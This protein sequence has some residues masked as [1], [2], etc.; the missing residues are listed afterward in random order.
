MNS[1][2]QVG[3]LVVNRTQPAW[4][5]GKIVKISPDRVHVLW[6]DLPDRRAKVMVASAVERATEQQDPV[7]DN[8]P[9]L[10][11]NDGRL[12][13]PRERLTFQ[14]AVAKFLARFPQGF[15]DPSYIGDM[16]H[17]E[18][19]Y[20]WAAHE[21]YVERLGGRLLRDLI[22]SDLDGLVHR[23]EQCMSQVNLLYMTESAAIRDALKD[24]SAAYSLFT[25]L[26]DLL[27][28]DAVS[29]AVFTPYAEAVCALPA[30]RGRVATWTVA[31]ILPYLAQPDRHILLKP[32]VT[33]KAAESLGFELNYRSDPN[34][35]TYSSLL[36]MAAIYR[37]KLAPLK[38][39]DLIDVQSFFFVTGGGAY[40]GDVPGK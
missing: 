28:A 7:L 27:E 32:E 16:H 38:P 20:K 19:R 24:A 26:A 4:G 31:T 1:T 39:V 2:L 35:L 33:K 40:G 12:L 23:V 21:F 37:E 5:P 30:E 3:T 17:G 36:R 9:P 15:S 29:E 10:V 14:Q 18:R 8:L 6:R 13:L 22:S 25:K 11:E 34:W